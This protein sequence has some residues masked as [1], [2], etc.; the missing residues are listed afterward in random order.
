MSSL[1]LPQ[2][3]PRGTAPLPLSCL[4]LTGPPQWVLGTGR[5]VG[6]CAA[7]LVV[8]RLLGGRLTESLAE[9]A[10][11]QG[12]PGR[13]A[14]WV[15]RGRPGG[16]P[17]REPEAPSQWRRPEPCFGMVS[18]SPSADGE[19][20]EAEATNWDHVLS[21]GEPQGPACG[22]RSLAACPATG[23]G[24]CPPALWGM[25]PREELGGP[26]LPPVPA[27]SPLPTVPVASALGHGGDP[28]GWCLGTLFLGLV[29]CATLSRMG[30][31]N[32][33]HPPL[34]LLGR[35]G[36]HPVPT[37]PSPGQGQFLTA[38]EG[39]SR[40]SKGFGLLASLFFFIDIESTLHVINLLSCTTCH[41]T[42][43][44]TWLRHLSIT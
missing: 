34:Q 21:I 31:P 20:E 22:Q 4:L 3:L 44:T 13:Q 19:T 37:C 29:F 30:A 40:A 8:A 41:V 38:S 26:L 14:A 18:P 27:P 12:R 24:S 23:L 17:G 5:P 25:R 35:A 10:G 16:R 43:T 32:H 15:G 7:L 1:H 36:S 39:V 11:E 2:V 28:G 9:S 33:S 6:Q 42:V